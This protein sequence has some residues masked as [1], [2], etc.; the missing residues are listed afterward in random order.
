VADL[1]TDEARKRTHHAAHR[2][3]RRLDERQV[4]DSLFALRSVLGNQMAAGGDDRMMTQVELKD[5]ASSRWI[6]IGAHTRSHPALAALAPEEQREEVGEGRIA[7]E[8]IIDKPVT[9]FAYPFGTKDDFDQ[10]T[11][12]AVDAAGFELA[13]TT[14]AGLARPGAD[15]RTL[16]RH[17]VGDWEP[18]YF[19]LQL[20]QWLES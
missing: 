19:R 2:R 12:D 16:P 17:F 7:L 13:C 4:T 1:R 3:M 6:N 15:R 9:T 18:S 14:V 20:R 8:A 5:L 10:H 11:L